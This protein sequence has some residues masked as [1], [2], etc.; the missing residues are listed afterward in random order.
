MEKLNYRLDKNLDIPLYLQLYQ[1]IKQAICRQELKLGERLPSKRRLCEYLQ[2][3]QNTVES[4]YH[5]LSAE[6]Y[7]QSQARQ[8][9]FVCFQAEL[10][11]EG[12]KY[13]QKTPHFLRA[14]KVTFDFNP[15]QIDTANFPLQRWKKCGRNCFGF[16]R[17]ELL[18]LGDNQG[19]WTLRN[20]IAAYL[21]ASRG[22][23]CDAEQI[24]IAAGVE[25]CLQQLILLFDQCYPQQNFTYAMENY[26]YAKVERLLNL[27]DKKVIKM[28]IHPQDDGVDLSFLA[29]QNVNVAFLTPSHLY[30]F[31]QVMPI[32]QR[33]RLLEWASGSE[34][35]Y[36]IEDDY[37]SEFRYKGKPIP[38]LQSLD[39]NQKVIYLGSFSKLLMPSLRLSFMVLPKTLLAH[40]RRNFDFFHSSVSRFEQQ[41]LANFM[42]QGEF[43]KHLHR[44]R[45]I[46]RKKMEL[47]CELLA[48]YKHQLRYY[49]E[50]CGFYLLVE[51]LEEKRSSAELCELA[52]QK[53]IRLYPIDYAGKVL[54][55]MGFGDLTETQLESAV[56][57]LADLWRLKSQ[58]KAA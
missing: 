9:F 57:I 25:S 1:Q 5:Q 4:A 19:D 44:M 55:S 48:P 42:Q 22:V 56:I 3:S 32:T 40:Y 2:I 27:Y 10:E 36:I 58:E 52:R 34:Q 30:P 39:F 47:L 21:F 6:G 14:E 8:G 18:G 23:H 31:G 12:E 54:F 43:E 51:L 16:H 17:R 13:H 24:V 46:Y 29:Q 26:G 33:Q 49:G 7:V 45:K 35:R 28:P 53:G 15:N 50:H 37:D 41:R 11:F 38:S 20:E